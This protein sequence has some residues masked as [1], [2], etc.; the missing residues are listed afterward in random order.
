MGNGVSHFNVSLIVM[1]LSQFRQCPST[2]NFEEKKTKQKPEVVSNHGPYAYK[3]YSLTW[4]D[5][6]VFF[7]G[8]N[9]A[10][11][12]VTW[13]FCVLVVLSWGTTVCLCACFSQRSTV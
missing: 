1:A 8:G 9:H 2:P 11:A 5:W 4:A 6:L 7:T 3:P 13:T 10:T 12:N